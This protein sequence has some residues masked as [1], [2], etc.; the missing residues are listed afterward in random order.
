MS[1]TFALAMLW[2]MVVGATRQMAND[3]QEEQAPDRLDNLID[4]LFQCFV[5]PRGI[6]RKL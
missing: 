3:Q 4:L 1:R 5:G 2:M 6:G